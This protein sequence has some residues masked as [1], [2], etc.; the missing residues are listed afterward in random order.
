M[1]QT[2]SRP[3]AR[4][5]AIAKSDE[6]RTQRALLVRATLVALCALAVLAALPAFLSI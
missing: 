6:V 2:R 5:I 1:N 4:A 3:K